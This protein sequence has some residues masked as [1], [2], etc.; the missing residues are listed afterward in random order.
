MFVGY[1]WS[2]Y[3]KINRLSDTAVTRNGLFSLLYIRLCRWDKSCCDSILNTAEMFIFYAFCLPSHRAYSRPYKYSR[4]TN[5][6]YEFSFYPLRSLLWRGAIYSLCCCS[7]WL[8]SAC[9]TQPYVKAVWKIH[10][11]SDPFLF[12]FN[13]IFHVKI[14]E[15]HLRAV[16]I[17]SG[18][19]L[20]F[21]YGPNGSA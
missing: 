15:F 2:N 17:Q 16:W 11:W 8:I 13:N 14:M 21:I 3:N 4:I 19:S 10:R 6:F 12:K 7:C 5:P 20:V 1:N 9:F 18:C